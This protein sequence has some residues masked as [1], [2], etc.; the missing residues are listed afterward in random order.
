MKGVDRMKKIKFGGR[1]RPFVCLTLVLALAA[2]SFGCSPRTEKTGFIRGAL[3]YSSGAGTLGYRDTWSQ[4]EQSFTA[5]MDVS[6]L[7]VDGGADFCGCDL[8]YL[9][10]SVLSAPQ[11]K[12]ALVSYVENGGFLLAPGAFNGYFEPEFLGVSRAVKLD[13]APSGLTFPP[14]GEDL[15]RLQGLVSDFAEIYGKYTDY[16]ELSL[17]DYGWGFVPDTAVSL[18]DAGEL[19]LYGLNEW[20]R[21]AVLY[22][23]PLLPNSFSINGFSMQKTDEAQ[24]HFVNSTAT[25]NQLFLSEFAAYVS[26]RKLGYAVS[27]VLGSFTAPD[28]AWQLHYEEYTGIANH[29]AEIFAE[30]CREK[31]L[32]PSYTLIRNTYYWLNKYETVTYLMNRDGYHMDL[33]QNAYSSGTHLVEDGGYMYINEV[34]D[35]GSYFVDNHDFMQM[36]YPQMCE[37]SGDGVTDLVCGCSDGMFYFFEGEVFD[38]EWRVKARQTLAEADGT[39][40]TVGSYSSPTMADFDGDGFLDMVSGSA[41]GDLYYF[42]GGAGFEAPELMLTVPDIERAMPCAADFDGDGRTD[43]AVGSLNGRIVL[44][45]NRD[46]GFEPEKTVE[47]PGETFVAPCAYDYDGDGDMDLLYGNFDGYIARLRNDGGTYTADG[48]Y[49]TEEKNYK[50]NNRIKFGNNCVPRFFDL[51]GDGADD[52]IAGEL[53]YGLAIPIDSPHYKYG[54]DLQKT[55]DYLRDNKFYLGVH[56]YTN[57]YAS[58]ER[59]AEELLLHKRAFEHYGIDC[60]NMGVNMHTWYTSRLAPDQTVQSARKAGFLWLSG[61]QPSRSNAVPQA[62]AESVLACPFF[63]DFKNR[64]MMVTNCSVLAY[65]VYDRYSD[66]SAKYDLPVSEYF[67]CDMV[68]RDDT[69]SRRMIDRV[70]EYK[71]KNGYNFVRED[72][73]MKSA[74][75]AYNMEL[76]AGSGDGELRLSSG[77]SRTGFPLYDRTYQDCVGVRL[78][79]AERIDPATVTVDANVWRYDGDKRAL[80]LGLDREAVVG[81]GSG[82]GVPVTGGSHILAVN[83][84]AEVRVGDGSAEVNFEDDGMMQVRVEGRATAVTPG[85]TAETAGNTTVFTRFGEAAALEFTFEE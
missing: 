30:M 63:T 56:F 66:M 42:K 43:L 51:D 72:Q 69:E 1:F 4:L 9:D 83:L 38:G 85:W 65:D 44:Y 82:S 15:D 45:Y 76:S 58:P 67:H 33:S 48:Y 80:Y 12:D 21:G 60:E 37:I 47:C 8:I 22:T 11:V 70:S 35:T 55:V 18:A 75:A 84:P 20:G 36:A 49:E 79:L 77:K 27:R 34:T 32:I 5:N 61:G 59:E 13:S 73:F 81:F 71:E 10:E 14:A 24:D 25:A 23:N 64:E 74:A 29:S 39:T 19:S 41:G 16:D 26:K 2:G 31:G 46:S 40:F 52:L 28:M 53:E 54:P 62:S 78:D 57:A 50:G 6:L 17:R 7:D 68:Y 3:V